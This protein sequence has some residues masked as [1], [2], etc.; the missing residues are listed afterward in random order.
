MKDLD[1]I[2]EQ[3]ADPG[4]LDKAAV[5]SFLEE[6][7]R[8]DMEQFP[9]VGEGD[10]VRLQGP[11]MTGGGLVHEDRLVHLCV[12]RLQ[13]GARGNGNTPRGRMIRASCRSRLH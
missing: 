3:R 6:V 10:D 2:D 8:A 12:F 4:T 1:A 11:H 5:Q 7:G 13:A 9:G